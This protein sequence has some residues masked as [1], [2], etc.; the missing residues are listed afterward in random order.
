MRKLTFILLLLLISCGTNNEFI[1]ISN[2]IMKREPMYKSNEIVYL[3]VKAKDFLKREREIRNKIYRDGHLAFFT[4]DEPFCTLV[5]YDLET[6]ISYCTMWNS[7]GSISFNYGKSDYRISQDDYYSGNLERLISDWHI[8]T[9]KQNIN[10]NGTDFDGLDIT[11]KVI[12]F[13][14]NGEIN[15]IKSFG[16]PQYDGS[17]KEII[18]YDEN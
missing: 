17:M 8:E 13:K 4:T 16:F 12:D 18:S 7:K 15:E 5:G 14:E 1:N 10:E 2:S 6:G 3:S 11:A 9:I